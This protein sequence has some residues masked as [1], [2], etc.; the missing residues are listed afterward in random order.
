VTIQCE[1]AKQGNALTGDIEL[2]LANHAEKAV[3]LMVTGHGYQSGD[4][5]IVIAPGENQGLPLALA[6]SHRWYDFSL[7]IA[8]ADRFLR[9]FAGRVETG[10]SGFSDPV[11]GRVAV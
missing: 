9:R 8:G 7:T 3:T 10:E 4:H 2:Q 11:M 6:Q 1:Y 5:S